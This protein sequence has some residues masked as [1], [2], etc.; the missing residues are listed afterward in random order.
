M[1]FAA[2]VRE[3]RVGL[4]RCRV[5]GLWGLNRGR[6][7]RS[8]H[9]SHE[10]GRVGR[11]GVDAACRQTAMCRVRLWRVRSCE[12]TRTVTQPARRIHVVNDDGAVHDESE[13]T[14]RP[15]VGATCSMTSICPS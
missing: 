2:A 15:T 3:R 11:V 5:L 10:N 7:Q 6:N 4:N 8:D 9:T 14:E 1:L 12:Q 13:I